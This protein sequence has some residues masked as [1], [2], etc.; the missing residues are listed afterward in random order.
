MG[1]PWW[2]RILLLAGIAVFIGWA[3]YTY[4]LKDKIK[5]MSDL[6]ATAEMIQREVSAL[7]MKDVTLD[8]ASI[9]REINKKLEEISRKVPSE[10]D[11]PYLLERF[12][13]QSLKGLDIDYTFIQPLA[14]V[15]EDVFKRIPINIDMTAKFEPLNLYLQRIENL[16]IAIRIDQMDISK[17][18]E[19]PQL[20]N[21]KLQLSAFVMPGAPSATQETH[22]NLAQI[23]SIDPFF[24]QELR[25]AKE[26]DLKKVAAFRPAEKRKP[27]FVLPKFKGVY[28]GKTIKA[29]INN[30]LFGVG[31]VVGGYII[32][33]IT[34]KYVIVTR[35]GLGYT[36][37]LG[38]VGKR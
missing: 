2:Q 25:A 16:P 31:D 24:E 7:G 32:T 34:D 30:E 6:K 9:N 29:F 33:N 5:E 20:L 19:E 38:E 26:A 14:P 18:R 12:I 27:L 10:A 1:R 36:L 15:K 13:A 3:S 4:L 11:S 22:P 23:P 28:K 37:K 35:N 21:V 17:N 8:S